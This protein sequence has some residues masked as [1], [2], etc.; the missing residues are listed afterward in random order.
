MLTNTLLMILLLQIRMPANAAAQSA[1]NA[2]GRS[3][4]LSIRDLEGSD[5]NRAIDCNR[6]SKRLDAL[7][8]MHGL[9][10]EVRLAAAGARPQRNGFNNK[11]GRT[12][13]KAA[14]YMLELQGSAPTVGAMML[15]R[16]RQ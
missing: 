4:L 5:R 7:N 1:P 16:G 8:F 3:G 6:F 14:R 9:G 12:L 13:P 2:V 15:N 10:R 11:Q